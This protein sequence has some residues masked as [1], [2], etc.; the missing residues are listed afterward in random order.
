MTW[1]ETVRAFSSEARFGPP[2]SKRAIADAEGALRV[3][4]PES[5]RGVLLEADGV[6]GEYGL[7]LIWSIARIREDNLHFRQA[8]H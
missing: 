1:R 8:P 2:G 7:G 4:F 5:L 6:Q 3:A